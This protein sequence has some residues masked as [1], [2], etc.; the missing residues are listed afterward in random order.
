MR[1]SIR[2]AAAAAVAVLMALPTADWVTAAEPQPVK[3]LLQIESEDTTHSRLVELHRHGKGV[4]RI[5]LI[6]ARGDRH[7][8]GGLA[9][10]DE[11]RLTVTSSSG[12]VVCR[13]E[14]SSSAALW[15]VDVVDL[16]GDNIEE[17]ILVNGHGRGTAARFERLTVFSP[18]RGRL[19]ERLST[20]YS[21]CE[22]PSTLCW[23]FS[24]HYEAASDGC[25]DL[26]L[27]QQVN[28]PREEEVCC[29]PADGQRVISL[30]QRRR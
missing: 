6:V 22:I 19:V 18:H 11:F 24:H 5:D 27:T 29:V 1:S 23:E 25:H 21:Q 26:V 8:D 17:I 28:G 20:P 14:F 10:E 15:S 4:V 12:E 2:L 30:R 3:P 13:H 7:P 9:G 16:D